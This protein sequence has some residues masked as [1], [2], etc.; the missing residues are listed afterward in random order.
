M[1]TESSH[2]T[3]FRLIL[4]DAALV[5]FTALTI[6]AWSRFWTFQNHPFSKWWWYWLTMTGLG[7]G[8]AVSSKWVGL[9]VIAMVGTSTVKDLWM[10]ITDASLPLVGF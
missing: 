2:I 10:K 6:Y 5:F 1:P 9:F 8:A 3:Q 4:L 7:M